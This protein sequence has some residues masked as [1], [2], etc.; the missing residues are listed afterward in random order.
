M[1]EE[2]LQQDYFIL[3]SLL[4]QISLYL[5]H[6]ICIQIWRNTSTQKHQRQLQYMQPIVQ[7]MIKQIQQLA[8]LPLLYKYTLSMPAQV[9]H[10]YTRFVSQCSRWW[11]LHPLIDALFQQCGGIMPCCLNG[12]DI[13]IMKTHTEYNAF[14][15]QMEYF[16]AHSSV[17]HLYG[18]PLVHWRMQQVLKAERLTEHNTGKWID[19]VLSCA[20]YDKELYSF[21]LALLQSYWEFP[22]V[23]RPLLTYSGASCSWLNRLLWLESKRQQ[24]FEVLLVTKHCISSAFEPRTT[25]PLTEQ[26]LTEQTQQYIQRWYYIQLHHLI[27]SCKTSNDCAS[28]ILSFIFQ[29]YPLNSTTTLCYKCQHY[30]TFYNV[31]MK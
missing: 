27:L 10:T 5:S 31:T 23:S 17:W 25:S 1:F 2:H 15:L 6:K 29:C 18:H 7:Q 8:C 28:L 30:K 3:L 16:K 21:C 20:L 12:F 22:H 9:H 24:L 13:E 26:Q 11:C 19:Y 4:K 14:Y